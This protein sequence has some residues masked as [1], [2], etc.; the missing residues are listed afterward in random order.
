M[1]QQTNGFATAEKYYTEYGS[2]ARESK[3]PVKRLLAT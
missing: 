1:K 3:G 2:R